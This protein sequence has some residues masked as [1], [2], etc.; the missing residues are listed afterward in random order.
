MAAGDMDIRALVTKAMYES[1]DQGVREKLIKEALEHLITPQRAGFGSSS[2][3]SPLD[4]EFR[5]EVS[6]AA[7]EIVREKFRSDPAI[8]Q[9]LH[10]AVQAAFDK[11]FAGDEL[12]DKMATAMSRLFLDKERF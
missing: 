3:A 8:R 10:D 11:F 4:K 6:R 7:T 2:E 1:L 5:Q 12:A 9:R